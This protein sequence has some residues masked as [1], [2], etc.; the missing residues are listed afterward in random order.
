MRSVVVDDARA[1]DRVD[2]LEDRL[3]VGLVARVDGDVAQRAAVVDLDQVDGADLAA[4][5]ADRADDLAERAGAVL[6]LDADRE[7]V[8]GGG[9]GGHRGRS[10]LRC[11]RS[12]RLRVHALAAAQPVAGVRG[13]PGRGRGPQSHDVA[14][15]VAHRDRVRAA[16]RR[17]SR[18]R[19]SR[20]SARPRRRRPRAGRRPAPPSRQSSPARPASPSAP[21]RPRSRS[22][23]VVPPSASSAAVPSRALAQR[24]GRRMAGG[25]DHRH[26]A[27]RRDVCVCV[28]VS[29]F[30]SRARPRV[31]VGD[32]HA[33]HARRRT[34]VSGPGSIGTLNV[35]SGSSTS[36]STIGMVTVVAE[37][38]GPNVTAV[39]DR[40]EVVGAS[41]SRRPSTPARPGRRRPSRTG[42]RARAMTC[43][44]ARRLGHAAT[45]ASAR[46]TTLFTAVIPRDRARRR[47]ADERRGRRRPGSGRR[48]SARR[49]ASAVR[50]AS[51]SGAMSM[52]D[53]VGGRAGD[54]AARAHER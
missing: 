11:A 27:G 26:A 18:S 16:R 21:P 15:A 13:R 30:V 47:R 9:G 52:C 2:G 1:L 32:R 7:G 33:R 39:A 5:A 35:S 25:G 53:R 28:T 37:L 41:R 10:I 34:G 14:P 8:L 43:T 22:P 42:R 49:S 54:D 36:S 17:R 51:P 19:R 3:P 29:V 12:R 46:L 45:L 38:P 50:N 6:D 40:R 48:G 24:P 23:A 44:R 20:P 4:G 31:V